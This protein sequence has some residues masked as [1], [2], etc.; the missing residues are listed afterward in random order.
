MSDAAF[1]IIYHIFKGRPSGNINQSAATAPLFKEVF[2]D[3]TAAHSSRQVMEAQ[4]EELEE[5]EESEESEE[6]GG[7]ALT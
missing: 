2:S 6:S 5:L 7:F 3:I 4:V 1:A